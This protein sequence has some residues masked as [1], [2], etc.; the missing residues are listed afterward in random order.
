MPNLYRSFCIAPVPFHE[1]P[2]VPPGGDRGAAGVRNHQPVGGG[3]AAGAGNLHRVRAALRHQDYH[4]HPP[5]LHH[6]LHHGGILLKHFNL[7]CTHVFK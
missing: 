5:D 2:S 4:P 3:S 6:Y 7:T 1:T